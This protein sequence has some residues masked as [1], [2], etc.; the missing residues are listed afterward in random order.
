MVC[1]LQ[2]IAK[3]MIRATDSNPLALACLARNCTYRRDK[4]NKRAWKEAYKQLR[5]L[6]DNPEEKIVLG[7]PEFAP[8]S[9]WAAMRMCLNSLQTT[10]AKVILF[11]LYA[12]KGES[13]PEEVLRMLH[14][15]RRTSSSTF[16]TSI[17]ELEA[18]ELVKPLGE[19]NL[20]PMSLLSKSDDIDEAEIKPPIWSI[21]TVVKLYME[22]HMANQEKVRSVIGALVNTE[23]NG[24]AES[25]LQGEVSREP[26]SE[27]E[28]RVATILCA[29]YFDPGH[30]DPV[31]T[32]AITQARTVLS[33]RNCDESLLQL[34]RTAIEPMIWLLDRPKEENWL[35]TDIACA[36][37]V[38][39]IPYCPKMVLSNFLCPF[40]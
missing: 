36:R 29:L 17:E 12:S 26:I 14:A 27:D 8:R 21:R 3:D 4:K 7:H 33:V 1:C 5:G 19:G 18:R 39:G 31:V 30:N 24:R 38:R 20:A 35:Q 25:C 28:T 10:D 9:L 6:L 34:R 13:L 23:E 16:S 40:I 37:K 32:A 2:V 11:F 22:A 15:R